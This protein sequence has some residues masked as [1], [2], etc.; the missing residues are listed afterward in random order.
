MSDLDLNHEITYVESLAFEASATLFER[1]WKL[2]MLKVLVEQIGGR[3]VR[4][5]A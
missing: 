2:A 5:D 4:A 1:A 3:D